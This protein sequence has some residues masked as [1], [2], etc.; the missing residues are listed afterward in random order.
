MYHDGDLNGIIQKIDHSIRFISLSEDQTEPP[1]SKNFIF[2]L[3]ELRD[4]LREMNGEEG[5]INDY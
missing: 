5:I 3:Y 2:Y 4:M 1:R